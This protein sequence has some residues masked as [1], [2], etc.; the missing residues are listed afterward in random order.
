MD[1]CQKNDGPQ[2]KQDIALSP[3]ICII[4]QYFMKTAWVTAEGLIEKVDAYQVQYQQ[5]NTGYDY[6]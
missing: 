2:I 5:W 1:A 3:N 4:A 6:H